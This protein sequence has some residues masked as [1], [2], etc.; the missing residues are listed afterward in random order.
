MNFVSNN[1]KDVLIDQG[2]SQKW[3]YEKVEVSQVTMNKWCLNKVQ[4]HYA[5]ILLIGE[6]LNVTIESLINEDNQG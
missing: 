6:K 4:P 5:F 1:I 3:L 2:R